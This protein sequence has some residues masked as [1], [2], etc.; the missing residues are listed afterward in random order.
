MVLV[1]GFETGTTA[2]FTAAGF[3]AFG[4]WSVAAAGGF[5][6]GTAPDN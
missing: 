2:G 3:A 5:G 1:S 4:S 6:A